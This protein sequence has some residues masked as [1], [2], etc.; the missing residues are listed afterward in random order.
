[1]CCR[2]ERNPQRRC[3]GVLN[4]ASRSLEIDLR[5]RRLARGG[6]S[7]PVWPAW[8][9]DGLRIAFLRGHNLLVVDADGGPERRLTRGSF[10]TIYD[11]SWS[12]DGRRI[13]FVAGR[14]GAEGIYVVNADGSGQRRLTHGG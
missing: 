11:P 6:D 2:L 9:P 8:S 1:M 7:E 3:D 4:D 12:Q 14:R 10:E 5:E 13:A